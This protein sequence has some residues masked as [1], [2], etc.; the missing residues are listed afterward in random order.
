VQN[1]SNGKVTAQNA[2][3]CFLP[4]RRD[5]VVNLSFD[6]I[7]KQPGAQLVPAA[8]A[9]AKNVENIVLVFAAARQGEPLG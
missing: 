7:A 1:V 9:Y 5:R 2:L 8:V 6:A 4:V 3:H